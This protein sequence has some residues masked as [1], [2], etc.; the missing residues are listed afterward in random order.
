MTSLAYEILET[1]LYGWPGPGCPGP[2][3]LAYQGFTYSRET[4]LDIG[5]FNA[6]ADRQKTFPFRR[7]SIT[8]VV[9]GVAL[10]MVGSRTRV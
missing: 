6:T 10:L 3:A 2:I 1:Y 9:A 4:V 5:P 7:S 8:A